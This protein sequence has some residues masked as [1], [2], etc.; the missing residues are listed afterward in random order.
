VF[1]DF[2]FTQ[3]SGES[4]LTVASSASV[5]GQPVIAY[6]VDRSDIGRLTD[7]DARHATH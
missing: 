7:L 6:R 5:I 2:D 1:I 4:L 3:V